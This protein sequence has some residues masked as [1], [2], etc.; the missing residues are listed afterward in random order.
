M[1]VVVVIIG[2]MVVFL[3]LLL[4]VTRHGHHHLETCLLGV[5]HQLQVLA[6]ILLD[7]R[8]VDLRLHLLP[9]VKDLLVMELL[10]VDGECHRGELHLHHLQVGHLL[11]DPCR[12]HLVDEVDHLL[13]PI[14]IK[15]LLE[16]GELVDNKQIHFLTYWELHHL[17]LHLVN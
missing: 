14:G 7:F 6:I 9:E 10:Q 2:V 3:H 8:W 13:C 11:P 5:L 17:H 1:E 12:L 15:V 4:V 16:V